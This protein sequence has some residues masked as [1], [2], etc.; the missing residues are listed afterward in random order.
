M[1]WNKASALQARLDIA[2][3]RVKRQLNIEEYQFIDHQL[4][5]EFNCEEMGRNMTKI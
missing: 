2:G 3:V 5:I 1:H 4:N